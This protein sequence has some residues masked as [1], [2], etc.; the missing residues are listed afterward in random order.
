MEVLAS[1][2]SFIIFLSI[3]MVL[4][5]FL[6]YVAVHL[7][8]YMAIEFGKVDLLLAANALYG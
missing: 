8:R 2:M 1:L 7:I 5:C 4:I 6:V 3:G